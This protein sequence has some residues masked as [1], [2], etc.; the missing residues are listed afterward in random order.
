V[1]LSGLVGEIR[2]AGSGLGNETVAAW[3]V[4]ATYAR[5]NWKIFGEVFQNYGVINPVRYTSL[6]PSNRLT[7]FL[8]GGHYV[9]GPVTW[10]A[11]WSASI[12]ENPSAVQNLVVAGCTIK[13][14]KGIDVY[15]EYVNQQVNSTR[16][17]FVEFF[18]SLE[19]IVYW[20]Y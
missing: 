19:F 20:S 13:V 10:R 5:G 3:A 11:S 8:A 7:G 4:D 1:G 16:G 2:D 9:T 12:D 17:G 14:T 18:N 15:L 6:G